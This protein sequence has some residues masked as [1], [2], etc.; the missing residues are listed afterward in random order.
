MTRK[1][2]PDLGGVALQ[3]RFEQVLKEIQ[4]DQGVASP[5]GFTQ[6]DEEAAAAATP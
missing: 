2:Y 5:G 3:Q 6:L 4:K 1:L